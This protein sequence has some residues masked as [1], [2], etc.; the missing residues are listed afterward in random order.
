MSRECHF[1]QPLNECPLTAAT[2]GYIFRTME[3]G[4]KAYSETYGLSLQKIAG[5]QR[6]PRPT[7]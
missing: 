7:P 6:S 1:P 2:D 4:D 3:L 5:F